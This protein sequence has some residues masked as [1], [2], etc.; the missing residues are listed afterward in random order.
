M[1]LEEVYRNHKGLLFGIAYRMLGS[2]TDAEDI[3]QE[4]FLSL[5]KRNLNH[6]I[7]VKAF[8]VKM[9]TNRCINLLQSS[10]R[11]RESYLGPWLPEPMLD[12][13]EEL[14]EKRVERKE[15]VQYALLVILQTLTPQER[16]CSF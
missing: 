12:A 10:S 4:V 11:Q 5:S 3:V 15:Q 1:I 6:I 9:T 16:H 2:V 14:P 13:S 7:D 8:L